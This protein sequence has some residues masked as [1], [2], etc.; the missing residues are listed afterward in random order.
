[1]SL[2]E[3]EQFKIWLKQAENRYGTAAHLTWD[4]LRRLIKEFES[5][6]K[7]GIDSKKKTPSEPCE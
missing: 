5:E 6:T 3:F 7:C 2:S 4:G 1:M